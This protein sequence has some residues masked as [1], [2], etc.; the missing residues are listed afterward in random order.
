MTPGIGRM[1]MLAAITALP[2]M[3]AAGLDQL[4][5]RC[6]GV[7]RGLA[8]RSQIESGGRQF[9]RCARHVLGNQEECT[10][11]GKTCTCKNEGPAKDFALCAFPL[12]A[13]C[14]EF[15]DN[16]C[17]W[18]QGDNGDVTCTCPSN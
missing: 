13:A 17:T 11:D 18:S 4:A 2:S 12:V 9:A 5:L 16:G 3:A 10:D 14:E 8:T 6:P 1:L 15:A 7:P